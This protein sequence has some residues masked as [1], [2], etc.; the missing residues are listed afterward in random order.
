MKY[1]FITPLMIKLV[2]IEAKR[3]YNNKINKIL[4]IISYLMLIGITYIVY[5]FENAKEWKLMYIK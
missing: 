2:L 5:H 3:L 1:E 4:Y